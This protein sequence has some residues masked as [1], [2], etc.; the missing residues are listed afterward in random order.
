MPKFPSSADEVSLTIKNFN[1]IRKNK[2]SIDN[3]IKS[4]NFRV[5]YVDRNM[6]Y[7]GEMVNE[8]FDGYGILI[9]PDE[10]Y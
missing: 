3:L 1:S 7:F 5:K 4:K 2:V 10:V 9:R 8:A 6:L